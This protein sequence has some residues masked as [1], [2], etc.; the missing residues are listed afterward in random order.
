[1]PHGL[2][3]TNSGLGAV[4]EPAPLPF[5]DGPSAELRLRG[6]HQYRPAPCVLIT[7]CAAV[8]CLFCSLLTFHSTMGVGYTMRSRENPW[9]LNAPLPGMPFNLENQETD[10]F[11]ALLSVHWLLRVMWG[12]RNAMGN[13][14][15]AARLAGSPILRR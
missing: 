1:M 11:Q 14:H 12:T 8:L 9:P 2:R 10:L 4:E 6:S 15:S 5:C 13:L 7:Q 3:R